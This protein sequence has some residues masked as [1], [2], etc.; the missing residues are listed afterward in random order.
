MERNDYNE[1]QAATAFLQVVKARGF[2]NAA[3]ALGKS[4]SAL[5][6]AVADL[7]RH[8]GVQLL[9]R[10]T[11][12][13]HLTEAGALY[14]QHAEALL[15]AQ[16][17]AHDAIAALTGGRP[18]GHLRVSMPTVVGER[19][20]GPRLGDFHAR[21]PE[22]VLELD[23]ADRVVPLVQGGFDLALR[24]G[25]LA[26]SAQRA[27]RLVDVEQVLVASPGYLA[28]AGT[29]AAPAELLRHTCITQRQLA[30]PVEWRLYRG[31]Q[32]EA[33]TVQGWLGTTSATLVEQAAVAG[34]GI[35]RISAWVARESLRAGRLQ[36]VLPDWSCHDP[37]EE[38]VGLHVVYAQGAGV[39]IPLKS[40]VFVDFVKEAVQAS[41]DEAAH[42]P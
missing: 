39:D 11:R 40:R 9:V 5:T 15:A 19:L 7:E 8:L 18:R 12:R 2:A 16:R 31:A 24:V 26:D 37:R 23:L 22:L 32:V 13:I 10:T 1:L 38:D 6:R 35:A 20:L 30:G 21:Y 3:R 17:Q 25:R 41:V 29:P 33:L 34:H 28:R 27:Q 4:P 14:L 42:T 36:R